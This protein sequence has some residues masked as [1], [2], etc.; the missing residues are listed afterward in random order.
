MV[1]DWLTGVKVAVKVDDRN[2]SICTVDGLEERKCDGV[3]TAE[4]DDAW[5]S[6]AL[7]GEALHV[8]VGGRGS[9]KNAVVS[10]LDLVQSPR[11]VVPEKCEQTDTGGHHGALVWKPTTSR[12]CR[13]S[14]G[15]WPSC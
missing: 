10:F 6:L 7:Q 1:E 4:G 13:H 3:V 11:V 9:R 14:P 5:Q 15:P 12:G 8:G 2:G